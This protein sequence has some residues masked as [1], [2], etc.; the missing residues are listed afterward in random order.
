MPDITIITVNWYSSE[1]L[2]ELFANLAQKAA[3]PDNLKVL[4]IDNTNGKD[5]TIN[6]LKTPLMHSIIPF[7]SR[8]MKSSLAHAAALDYAMNFIETDYTLVIDPD[9]YVFKKDWDKFCINELNASDA[10][11]AGA[12]YPGWKLGKYHDFPSPVFC[13]FRT[14]MLKKL[15]VP[16]TPFGNTRVYNLKVFLIRQLA[17]LCGVMTRRNYT[18]Y[19]FLRRYAEFIEK[20]FGTFSQDTG[21]RIAKEAGNQKL[22]SI[23]FKA[24]MPEQTGLVP[25]DARTL[26]RELANEYELYIYKD[27]LMLTH[28]YGTGVYLW[29]T[30]KGADKNY[31]LDCVRRLETALT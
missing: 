5:T 19:G 6:R 31:W 15:K 7:E 18:K 22:L 29:K 17:R 13:F 12:P 28:K 8:D 24:A 21:W 16:W 25:P 4:I 11:A 3:S 30:K 26:F 27:Q 2:A 1:Y 23:V 9:V 20:L 14:K 10:A